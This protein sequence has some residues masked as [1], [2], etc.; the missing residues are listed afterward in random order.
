MSGN[1][2]GGASFGGR[3]FFASVSICNYQRAAAMALERYLKDFEVQPKHSSEE[4]LRR[5]RSAV[6][7]VRNRCRR[8]R[9]VADL[10][11]RSEA[12][13]KK[14]KIQVPFSN[15][16]NLFNLIEISNLWII[17]SSS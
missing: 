12:E 8:F 16:L 3:T 15:P 14:L 11:K 10:D 1:E 2:A 13:Q 9:N 5:W 6:S 17:Y 7:L 4:A